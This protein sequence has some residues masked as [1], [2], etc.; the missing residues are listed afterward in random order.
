MIEKKKVDER[1][2][3]YEMIEKKKADEGENIYT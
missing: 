3:G 1:E 2:I